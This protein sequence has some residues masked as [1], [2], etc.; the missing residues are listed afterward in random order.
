[1]PPQAGEA[2]LPAVHHGQAALG[3]GTL[4]FVEA[5]AGEPLLL[6]HG[7][8]GSWTHWV[9]NIAPLARRRRVI[10]LDLP[11]FGAS[12]T[13]VPAYSIE[14]YAL[15][16]SELLDALALPRAAIAGFSF[17]CVVAA[18]AA[19]AEPRRLSHLALVNPPGI[20]PA[21]PIAADIMKS[22]SQLS[23]RAGLQRGAAE[24]LR[25]LQLFDQSLIDPALVSLMV[26][27]LRQTR[28]VSRALSRSAPTDRILTTVAQPILV[29]IGRE[30]LHR[31]YGLAETLRILP[32]CAPHAQIALVERARHWL[33]YD[34]AELF[35]ALL[36]DFVGE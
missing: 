13:P 31:Q 24:S 28:F 14:R 36:G 4:H 26:A 35:N 16:V 17:G 1:M 8:H 19:R 25:R 11:G 12:F 2:A 32:R 22:L 30:D 7:G 20:G 6:V 5:G 23:V 27:N 29:V 3:D 18:A 21:S 34:R 9:A 10:A 33:Q 15:V